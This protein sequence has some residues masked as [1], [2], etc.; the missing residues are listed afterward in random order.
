MNKGAQIVQYL[1]EL[2]QEL[3]VLHVSTEFHVMIAGGAF[4]LINKKRKVTYDID[5]AIIQQPAQAVTQNQ[6]FKTSLLRADIARRAS[7]VPGAAAFKQ[8]V[9]TIAHRQR[10]PSDWI[11]DESAAYYYDD[12]PAPE[13]YFWRSF[14]DIV[15]V[16]LPTLE[17]MLATKL[18]AYRQKDESDIHELLQELQVTARQQ[19]KE[20]V[21]KFLLPA[22]QEF[23]EIDDRL[24]DLFPD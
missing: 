10:L 22:G 11:N 14:S 20:I 21:N 16:Y 3:A 4:M 9:F 24:S 5:F 7:T 2:G 6:V 23:Y 12:A 13:V 19:A 17:Y 8:A 1:E 15:F 18:M